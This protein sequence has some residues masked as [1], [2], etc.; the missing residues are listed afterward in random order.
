MPELRLLAEETHSAGDV[1]AAWLP[2]V[3]VALIFLSNIYILHSGL[4]VIIP[5]TLFAAIVLVDVRGGQ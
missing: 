4:S 2:R 5:F 1:L 3:A